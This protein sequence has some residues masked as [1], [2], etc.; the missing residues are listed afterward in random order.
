MS[1]G[2][3]ILSIQ[4]HV[5]HGYVGN[6]AA[7]F[8]LQLHGFDVDGVNTVSLSNHSGY[9]VIRGH[10]M[11]L[12]EFN[13][14]LEGLRANGFLSGYSYIL[15]GYINNADVVRHVAS[16][17]AEVRELRKKSGA[18]VVFYCDPVLGDEGKLYC[19]EEVVEAYR[20]LVAHADVA[21]PNYYEASILSGVPVTDL[22]SAIEAADWFHTQ[23]TAT[24]IIK[25]FTLKEDP[26]HLRYL[27]SC[28]DKSS[29]V[30][31]RYTGTV[32]YH[33]GRYTGTGDVFAASLIAFSHVD[34]IDL[35]V[36]KAM[37]VL[38]DLI[39]ATINRGGSGEASLNSRELRVI[40]HPQ[41]LLQPTAVF[42]PAPLA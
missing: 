25:S 15:T 5:T 20:E 31:K 19:K 26:K 14:I 10:R 11:D 7:T 3:N 8:P 21:T 37:G 23:G 17:V 27:L 13:T 24:V 36:G 6:K 2:K 30:T 39:V 1:T 32:P 41:C 33:D 22:P 35:A 34:P 16:T 12:E 38:Q 42:M 28:H 9:P 40:D 29:N 4:S 18:E